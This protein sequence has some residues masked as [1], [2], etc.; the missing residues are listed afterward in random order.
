MIF[1]SFFSQG[2]SGE[3]SSYAAHTTKTAAA[4]SGRDIDQE[5]ESVNVGT[6]ILT[7]I[8]L[9]NCVNE[10]VECLVPFVDVVNICG[11]ANELA[12]NMGLSELS[13]RASVMALRSVGEKAIGVQGCGECLMCVRSREDQ[14]WEMYWV[15]FPKQPFYPVLLQGGLRQFCEAN[16]DG[17]YSVITI[18]PGIEPRII[19]QDLKINPVI[20]QNFPIATKDLV[21]VLCDDTLSQRFNPAI[22]L[23]AYAEYAAMFRE[24]FLRFPKVLSP[25]F[26]QERAAE[27]HSFEDESFCLIGAYAE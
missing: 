10:L 13:L 2:C 8:T 19:H 12:M 3:I 5:Y 21:V 18:A 7:H 11:T 6:R 16:D 25:G 14:T 23:R 17:D 1:D 27:L 24:S 22:D 26:L 9:L 15:R 4:S 20:W